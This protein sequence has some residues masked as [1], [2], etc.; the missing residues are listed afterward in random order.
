[1][2]N[3]W[4][5]D[6]VHKKG[7]WYKEIHIWKSSKLLLEIFYEYIQGFSYHHI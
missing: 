6:E 5:M 7:I 1:M 3:G 2:S 4:T